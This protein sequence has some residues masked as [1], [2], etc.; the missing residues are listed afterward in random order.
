MIRLLLPLLLF[1]QPESLLERA[2]EAFRS[3]ELEKAET[4]ARQALA[5]DPAA[6]HGHMILGVIAAQKNQWEVSNRHFLAILKLDPSN[7]FGYFYL[8]QA[9][10]YQE[11]WAQAV[12]YLSKAME[13]QYPDRER[14]IVELAMA[15]N[16]AGNPAQALKTL[17]L[18]EPPTDARQGAQYF[19]VTSFAQGKLGRLP[20]AAENVRRAI[21]LD[22]SNVHYWDFLIDVLIK[23][24][25][26]PQALAEAIRAQRKFPD[27]ADTQFLFALAS[28]HVVE[29]PLSKLALRNLREADPGDA[30][31]PFAEGLLYRKRGKTEEAIA[32]FQR[33]AQ[34][35]APDAHLLLGIVYKENGDYVAAER[36]YREAERHNPSNA[37]LMLELGK[38]YFARG[39]LEL[40]RQRLEKAVELAP[41]ASTIHYQLGLLYRRLGQTEKAKEHLAKS[42]Q[43]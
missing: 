41:D 30:R 38:L 7:P 40:A 37:Q 14:L 21:Q 6:V 4:L 17:A 16:E 34:Q 32:A 33:A 5:R 26:A 25:Q 20:E 13:H 12:N 8:G 10:L 23:T 11:Q 18:T 24:D 15:Q 19:G 35:G 36:E 28:H 2:D 9:K 29:S 27:D 22:D 39:E 3:G 1:F 42:K 43:Q 31:V